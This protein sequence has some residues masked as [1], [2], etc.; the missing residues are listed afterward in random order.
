MA[1]VSVLTYRALVS[2]GVTGKRV[3]GVRGTSC[4]KNSEETTETPESTST[5]DSTEDSVGITSSTGLARL[6]IG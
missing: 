2:M 6:L 1:W 5:R 4:S 3:V